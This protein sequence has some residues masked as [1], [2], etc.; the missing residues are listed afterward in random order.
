MARDPL[1]GLPPI[2]EEN[3][4][5]PPIVDE[6]LEELGEDD[7][8][9][10]KKDL[11]E[12]EDGSVTI[13]DE[14]D[15]EI[16][17]SF[18]DNLAE[19]ASDGELKSI[20]MDYLELIERDKVARERRDEQYE[21]GIRRTGLGNDA[22]GGATFSGASKVVHPLLAEGCIDFASRAIKELCP[23]NGPA[24]TQIIGKQDGKKLQKASRKR[25]FLN[26]QLTKQCPEFFTELEQMLSQLPLGGS[27]YVKVLPN[28]DQQRPEFEF[29]PVDKMLVP[30]AASNF[31][32]AQR[33]T[34]I[35]EITE[36]TFNE[37]IDSGYYR[38]VNVFTPDEPNSSKSETATR[39]VEGKDDTGYNEDGLRTV[40][41]ITCYTNIPWDKSV[42]EGKL[43]P[44][45]IV[46]DES[47][48][49][50]LAIYRNWEEDDETRQK[51][52]WVVEFKFIP[53]RGVMGIGLPHLIGG[54]SAALTGALRALLDSAHINNAPSALKLK[55]ARMG[56]Q[57]TQV[58]IGQIQ[59]IEA[60]PGTT[61]IRQLIMPMP[62]N[63][64]SPVLFQLLDWITNAAKGVVATAEERIA[65][66]GNNMP[67]GTA[68]ALI[69][70][71]SYN[72]S[73][74][75][76][77][78]HNSMAKLL[79]IVCRIDHG[80]LEEEVVIEALGE[81]IIYR[82]DFADHTDIIPVSDPNIFSESQRYAQVQAVMQLAT[83][84][85][86]QGVQYNMQ[87][88]HR[89]AL[90]LMK[91]SDAD[92]I[93]PKVE[94][95]TEMNA[96][97]ENVTTMLGKNIVAFPHQDHL[98]H[99]ES[100]LR[101]A[102]DPNFGANPM[103]IQ[104]T[105]PALMDH[106]NSHLAFL[107]AATCE[108]IANA[109]VPEGMETVDPMQLDHLLAAV[110][111]SV[112]ANTAQVLAPFMQM[113][114]QAQQM[115]Q[116]ATPPPPKDAAAVQ[117]QIGM[118]EIQ[119]QKE[120][121]QMEMQAKQADQ[122]AKAQAEQIKAQEA[123]AKAQADLQQ[124]Q[125]DNE[126]DIEKLRQAAEKIKHDATEMLHKAATEQEKLEL[127][128]E[129][130]EIDFQLKSAELQ[131]KEIEFEKKLMAEQFNSEPQQEIAED[132]RIDAL[133]ESQQGIIKTLMGMTTQQPSS[134]DMLQGLLEQLAKP[135]TINVLRDARG[136]AI[137]LTQE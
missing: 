104:K 64:P 135:K 136:R 83:Q 125:I 128:R 35:Q 6:K 44:Y 90:E 72:Y 19:S 101:F 20:A 121:D 69:E 86:Q 4:F 14:E 106:V 79:N 1:L 127:A 47:L 10:E 3:R 74:I 133:V 115:L 61:D 82:T 29:I 105:L 117:E 48:N 71:G 131:R 84:G 95:P 108:D 126:K 23:P 26:W 55:G 123:M 75:H 43:A 18:G 137:S 76:A 91:V 66:A 129:K 116:K 42:P 50:I 11:I 89:R 103:A 111:A 28:V 36:Q 107:Y 24:R 56:G 73:A 109:A 54:L 110:S 78:L 102:T 31:Y 96:L 63:Q 65:D 98:A 134:T 80:L 112:S 87:E 46:L 119:R 67:V 25:N 8:S 13:Y 81:E 22:P 32:T 34:H 70:Q 60:S 52:D 38:D 132:T 93:L 45:V 58:D 49:T 57:T 68:L 59:E 15:E 21:E 53:W 40:Y 120:R 114:Q 62:F 7:W 17:T 94:K 16:E 39:K 77:R 51:L 5:I 33:T 88:I 85:Q 99:I 12:N 30:F 130:Q 113:L 122:Q 97:A 100:H 27:Q 92:D 37:R 41:E 118:A 2:E 124:Q 9:T